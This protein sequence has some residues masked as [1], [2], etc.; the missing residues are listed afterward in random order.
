MCSEEETINRKFLLVEKLQQILEEYKNIIQY[1]QIQILNNLGFNR[2][3]TFLH[4][5][6]VIF[7]KRILIGKE[8]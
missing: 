1:V 5:T 8:T 7:G 2:Y 6:V 3:T 4:T